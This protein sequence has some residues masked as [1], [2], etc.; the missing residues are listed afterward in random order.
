[1]CASK[2]TRC[3][4]CLELHDDKLRILRFRRFAS[5]DRKRDRDGRG[6]GNAPQPTTIH[7]VGFTHSCG[8]THWGRFVVLRPT[9]VNRMRDLATNDPNRQYLAGLSANQPP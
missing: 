4:E 7:F 1:M 8:K 3:R 5:Q 9:M 6:G 2:P